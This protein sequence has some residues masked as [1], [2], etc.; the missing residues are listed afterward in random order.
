MSLLKRGPAGN[1]TQEMSRFRT[2]LKRFQVTG[3]TSRDAQ[4]Q[5]SIFKRS[6]D[7][8]QY[9]RDVQIQDTTQEMPRYR[10]FLKRCPDTGL[11]IQE[12]PR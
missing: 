3:H 5:D 4:I 12:K 1:N 10:A 11:Y 6:L 8:W 7:K 2:L 9:S